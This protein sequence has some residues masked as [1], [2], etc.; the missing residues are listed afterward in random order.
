MS[1]APFKKGK[2]RDLYDLGDK[3]LLVASDRVS[4]YD[5]ILPNNIP[6]KGEILTELSRFWFERLKGICPNHLI[7]TDIETFPDIGVEK[8]YL[9]GR[10][11]LV[12]K[13]KVVPVECI[14]RGYL[15]GSAW[16]EYQESGSVAGYKLPAG[17][18]QAEELSEPIFTPSTKADSGHDQNISRERMQELIGGNLAEQLIGYSFSIYTQAADFAKSRGIIVA[19]TKLEF[20]IIDGEVSLID[21]LLT[22]D[23]SRFW[24]RAGYKTGQSQMS[25]DKQYVRDYLDASG[26]NHQP[27]APRLPEEIVKQTSAKYIEAYE[28]ITGEKWQKANN[29]K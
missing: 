19:D 8:S 9:L 28:L 24:P 4:A 10:T 25:F 3:L 5:S 15:A 1:K 17:M 13:A 2:V 6:F 7:S 11:M 29:K 12:K 23:S 26:W 20:G 21:E 16:R 22:P 27:P 18:D 14:V